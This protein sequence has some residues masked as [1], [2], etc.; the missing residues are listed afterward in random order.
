MLKEVFPEG[1]INT[2]K[3]PSDLFEPE[4]LSEGNEQSHTMD[5]AES[6]AVRTVSH[7]SS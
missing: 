2:C 4:V 6:Q 1:F 3:A 5:K 7:S